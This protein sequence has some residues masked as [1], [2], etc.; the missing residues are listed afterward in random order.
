MARWIKYRGFEHHLRKAPHL[1]QQCRDCMVAVLNQF[2][3]EGIDIH[4][5]MPAGVMG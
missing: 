2:I 1:Y 3:D 4:F 5:V